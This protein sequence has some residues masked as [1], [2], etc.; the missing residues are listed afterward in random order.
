MDFNKI[1]NIEYNNIIIKII[2]LNEN[3]LNYPFLILHNLK[4]L[5]NLFGCNLNKYIC[6]IYKMVF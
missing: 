3:N 1:E 5:K 6:K 4:I 2:V